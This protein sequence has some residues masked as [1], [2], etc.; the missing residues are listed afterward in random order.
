M[1][2][3]INGSEGGC[4]LHA[5]DRN[6]YFYGK[7]LSVRD[8]EAE[9]SYLNEKRNLINRSVLANGGGIVCG[10]EVSQRGPQGIRITPGLALDS[11]GREMVIS[12][13]VVQ[14][15]ISELE[16]FPANLEAATTLLL[17]LRYA[18]HPREPVPALANASSCEEVCEYNRIREGFALVLQ[19]PGQTPIL[20]PFTLLMDTVTIFSS[21][22]LGLSIERT[23][24][25]WANPNEIVEVTLTVTTRDEGMAEVV[26]TDTLDR[27]TPVEAAPEGEVQVVFPAANAGR[28][29]VQT[30]LVQATSQPFSGGIRADTLRVGGEEQTLLDV[31]NVID[32][33]LEPL[34]GNIVQRAF[35]ERL[36]TCAEG[37]SDACVFLAA[38]FLT[39]RQGEATFQIDGISRVPLEQYVYNNPLL[40]EL[41]ASV[42]KRIG[43]Q[44][45]GAQA[46]TAPV[47]GQEIATGVVVFPD[48]QPAQT[49]FSDAINPGLG[50]GPIHVHLGLEEEPTGS[51][52]I[53]PSDFAASF[54][55]PQV[56]LGAVVD[57]PLAGQFRVGMQLQEE[58]AAA[59]RIR[60]WAFNPNIDKGVI[61]VGGGV[62]VVSVA[63]ENVTLNTG[64][65]QL[66]T[67]TVTGTANKA[68]N[69]SVQ[70]QGGGSIDATG[71]YTAPQAVGIFHVIATSVADPSRSDIS[72]VNV[73]AAPVVAVVIAPTTADLSTGAQQQF[74][75]TVTGT[76][77]AQVTWSVQEGALG[78]SVNATGL[79]QAP[80]GSGTFHVVATSVA[81]PSKSDRATVTVVAVAISVQPANVTRNVDETVQF[82][83]TVTGTDNAQVTWS[84]QE[85]ANGGSI[86]ESGRYTAPNTAGTFH[87]V[88]TSVA[89]PSKND[90]A[91][92]TVRRVSIS[93]SPSTV[94]IDARATRQFTATV[95]GTSDQRVTWSVREGTGGG[96]ITTSG[97]YTAPG[98]AGTFHVVATSVADS[99]QTTEATVTVRQ[100]GKEKEK[101]KEKE[102]EKDFKEKE[103]I[104][105]KII[106]E[107]DKE[108]DNGGVI[109]PFS[110][111][112]VARLG[113]GPANRLVES[114]S[115]AGQAFIRA[116]ERPAIEGGRA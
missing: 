116:E 41:I 1:A 103:I 90:I 21:E 104:H 39:P 38:L 87:V 75:A 99:R 54:N 107:K 59:V 67:A 9:Q 53:G 33:I 86:S 80:T 5:F 3:V 98:T 72:T 57:D 110:A 108:F 20:E 76:D 93:V 8:F 36:N 78:G 96:S 64:S 79:Y 43:A 45:A 35:Q 6:R 17:C 40:Y 112:P 18:E 14:A 111:G 113:E 44:G 15:N 105:D 47:S 28:R 56:L 26:L 73:Q 31:F 95:T 81:D 49:A 37:T 48:A 97:L 12:T 13:E 34:S 66:F 100:K 2:E 23:A 42:D 91:T 32:I 22:A 82:T 65:Q 89:D 7:L 114:Q 94:T 77:N 55:A 11:C 16:G 69:W 50:P 61:I 85:G 115:P 83:A 109:Q 58:Q 92:V 10:L 102:K 84:V 63:P 52:F 60:W 30:Y 24:P 62:V 27:F 106:K 71:R 46:P 51:L 68:V 4:Q 88:A 70:E 74:T 25:R 19:E 29:F 101:D